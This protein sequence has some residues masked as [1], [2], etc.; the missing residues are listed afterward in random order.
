[1][2]PHPPLELFRKFIRFGRAKLPL[3]AAGG[4]REANKEATEPVHGLVAAGTEEAECQNARWGILKL[5][6]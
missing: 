5:G 1:M 3:T 6:G 2:T 4:R